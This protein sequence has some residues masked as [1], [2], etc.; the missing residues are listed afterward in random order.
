MY[1]IGW[2]MLVMI[3]L[4]VSV[5]A[6]IWALRTGQFSDPGRARYLPLS[7]ELPRPSAKN[8][9]KFTAEVYVLLII[10]GM[11]FLWILTPIL[12]TLYRM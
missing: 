9:A 8:P 7:G 4:W 10:G 1:F 3:S 6:F 11:G 12:L 5:A 2:M